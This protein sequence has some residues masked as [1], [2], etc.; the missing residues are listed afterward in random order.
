[1]DV[2]L[3]VLMLPSDLSVLIGI[4]PEVCCTFVASLVSL[5][6]GI[7]KKASIAYNRLMLQFDPSTCIYSSLSPSARFDYS[8]RVW[9]TLKKSDLFT[10]YNH[11]LQSTSPD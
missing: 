3:C 1:M 7:E 11:I 9:L 2:I 4:K 8:R 10:E 6:I 5:F